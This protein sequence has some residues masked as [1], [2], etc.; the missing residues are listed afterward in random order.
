VGVLDE[1]VIGSVSGRSCLNDVM[2]F[3]D[4][5]KEIWMILSR[6]MANDAVFLLRLLWWL[7]SHSSFS[8]LV[9]AF[10]I[11]RYEHQHSASASGRHGSSGTSTAPPG[12]QRATIGFL[13][14]AAA[15]IGTMMMEEH[16]PSEEEEDG[17][18]LLGVDNDEEPSLSPS[19]T[20][21]AATNPTSCRKKVIYCV[22]HGQSISNE[23][24]E[25]PGNVWG[26][27]NYNDFG[28]NTP[29]APLS[30]QGIAQAKALTTTM[31]QSLLGGD[32]DEAVEL[33][34]VSPLT[35]CLETWSYYYSSLQQTTTTV[36]TTT[37]TTPAVVVVLPL[38]TERVYSL[39][40]TGRPKSTLL[41]AFPSSLSLC[42]TIHPNNWDWSH[43]PDHDES[44][45]YTGAG[46]TKNGDDDDGRSDQEEEEAEWRPH[47]QGQ[48]YAVP[49]EPEHVFAQ[50]MDALRHWLLYERP[51][52]ILLLVT[53]WGVIRYLSGAQQLEIANGQVARLELPMK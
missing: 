28:G 2:I 18:L 23:W 43:V 13:M 12:S 42:S 31:E 20:T 37:T 29:D 1:N 49:G 6:T 14:T 17:L 24:M 15:T 33:V 46:R 9:K 11:V 26:G 44:W 50:R 38:A 41:Q 40:E 4:V 27:V 3:S 39:S 19:R 22:R 45:W 5:N 7:L 51:E 48:V 35:R 8:L 10:S 52:R 32:C 53:H 34:V 25:R 16:P 47:G 36:A 21:N 30:D